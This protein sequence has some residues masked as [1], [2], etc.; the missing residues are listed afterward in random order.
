MIDKVGILCSCYKKDFKELE[1][2]L[3]S[4]SKINYNNYI[5]YIT[6][7]DEY[8]DKYDYINDLLNKYNNIT[9]K[10][11]Y[12]GKNVGNYTNYNNIINYTDCE[13]LFLSAPNTYIHSN[14]ISE[15]INVFNNNKNIDIIQYKYIRKN[16][17]F[18]ESL[19]DNIFLKDESYY[20][21]S[22]IF[23][24]RKIVKDVGYFDN[25]RYAGDSNLF[26][27]IISNISDKVYYLN[28]IGCISFGYCSS[29]K[30]IKDRNNYWLQT[31]ISKDS[32]TFVE[33]NQI[34]INYSF[35]ENIPLCI[36]II[37]KFT[38]IKK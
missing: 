3:L 9:Y 30:Y 34:K 29:T 19:I 6:I 32:Y 15:C 16:L 37:I 13:Y 25:V 33:N 31:N 2:T 11:F 24:K 17:F 36:I 22:M 7:D 12:F 10:I 1:L 26:T 5:I 38:I 35:L 27:R 20:G 28:F 23:F 14:F 8:N 21:D 18:D 4:V